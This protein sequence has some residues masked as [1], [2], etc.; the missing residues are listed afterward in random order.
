MEAACGGDDSDAGVDL[1]VSS[2]VGYSSLGL[3]PCFAQPE[4]GHVCDCPNHDEPVVTWEQD[5]DWAVVRA[6]ASDCES[7]AG[8]CT[9]DGQRKY[10]CE[11]AFGLSV[12][13]PAFYD[14]LCEDTLKQVCEP[15]C[16]SDRGECFGENWSYACRCAGD[17]ELHFTTPVNGYVYGCDEQLAQHCGT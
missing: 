1:P 14:P 9:F 15:A 11:C 4:G 6:C 13:R 3:L 2:C 10:Q 12:T 17:P 5:C 8:R 7:A 16:A